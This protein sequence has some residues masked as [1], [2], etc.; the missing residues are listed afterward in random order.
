MKRHAH[1][2]GAACYVMWGVM[3]V[4]IGV[5]LMSRLAAGGPAAY[6]AAMAP[7]GGPLAAPLPGL[8]AGILAQH[9]WNL[10]WFGVFAIVVAVRLNWKNEPVGYWTNLA[11]VSLADFGFLGAIVIPGF[12]RSFEAFLGPLLWL[13]GAAFTTWGRRSGRMVPKP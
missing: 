8:A 9:A 3:H 11:V 6:L 2:I 13:L 10:V 5:M 12:M 1:R 7:G 4:A